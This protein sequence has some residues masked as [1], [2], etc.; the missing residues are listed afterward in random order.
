MDQ[1]QQEAL[2]F[3]ERAIGASSS[4]YGHLR[5]SQQQVHISEGQERGVPAGAMARWCAGYHRQ[6]P[7]MRSYL[8]CLSTSPRNVIVSSEVIS[9]HDYVATR[10]YNEFLKPQSIYH[11]MIVGLRPSGRVPFGIIG[12]HRPA[13]ERG[14]SRLEIAKADLMAPCLRGAVERI[15]ARELL[16]QHDPLQPGGVDVVDTDSS[17]TMERRMKRF[18]LSRREKQ[19]VELL[20]QGLSSLHIADQLN[21]SAR[22][23]NNHL[24][25]V[26]DK[27]GVHNRTALIYQ[28]TH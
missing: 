24:R 9:H 17:I 10:F 20:R 19:V 11:V 22:T 5:L 1:L 14:F 28:L 3:M 4:V 8:T 23:V 21:I 25:S 2:T 27:C 7:F 26:Y 6:D 18:G 13:E 15:Q 16:S 12:L